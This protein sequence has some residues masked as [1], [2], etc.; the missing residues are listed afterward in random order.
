MHFIDEIST[1]LVEVPMCSSHT[2]TPPCGTR[3]TAVHIRE[4][5]R[6]RISTM[7]SC[8]SQVLQTLKMRQSDFEPSVGYFGWS[9]LGRFGLSVQF[10]GLSETLVFLGLNVARDSANYGDPHFNLWIYFYFCC[11]SVPS[12]QQRLWKLL[13]LKRKDWTKTLTSRWL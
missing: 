13:E 10:P 8:V 6:H 1:L 11:S 4:R 5:R 7:L 12:L 3:V 2:D 9:L